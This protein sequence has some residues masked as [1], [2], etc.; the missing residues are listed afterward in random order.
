VQFNVAFIQGSGVVV[1]GVVVVVVVGGVVVVVVV[2]GVVV[3]VVVGGVVVVV[4]GVGV[5]QVEDLHMQDWQSAS[6]NA[7]QILVAHFMSLFTL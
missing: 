5:S 7:F 1:G 4:F 2:G 3:V 6:I